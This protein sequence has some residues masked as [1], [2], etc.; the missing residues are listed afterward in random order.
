[1]PKHLTLGTVVEKNRIASAVAFILLAEIEVRDAVTGAF[2]ETIRLARNNENL[3]H[4][5][6]V[7][8]ATSFDFTSEETAEGAPEVTCVFQDQTGAVLA[9][10]EEH[11]GGV[12]WKVRFKLVSSD[13]LAAPAEIEELVYVLSTKAQNY[14]VEFT[15]GAANPLARRF[16]RNIQ[17]RDKCRWRFRSTECGYTGGA[18]TCDYTLQGD[19]GCSVKGNSL[20]FGGLPGIRP[21]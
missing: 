1:M 4:M 19:N 2:I 12:G 10:C 3:T 11:S 14:N 6:N 8:Q 21:R 9:R 20:R 17:W 13:D 16:P 15:L 7:Y 5:G 18:L